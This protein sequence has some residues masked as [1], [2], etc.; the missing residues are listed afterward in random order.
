[1]LPDGV[2]L[3]R[4]IGFGGMASVYEAR[5]RTGE[6]IAVKVMH[7]EMLAAPN[8][9][10]RFLREGKVTASL[11]HEGIPVVHAVHE[12][13]DGTVAIAMELLRGETV[14]DRMER[15][16]GYLGPQEVLAIADRVL[17]VLEVAHA[18][19]VLHRD[20]KPENVFLTVGG[21]LKVLDFG[22][23]RA[24]EAS[25][26]ALTMAG[27][28]LGT[29]A[30]MSPEQAN[31]RWHE[32][33]ARTDLWAVGATMFTALAGEPPHARPEAAEEL[34]A[35]S[36][37]DARPVGSVVGGLKKPV[38]EVVDKVLAKKREDRYGSATEMRA[39]VRGAW[40]S[41][42]GSTSMQVVWDRIASDIIVA[43]PAL[44]EPAA[45][46]PEGPADGAPPAQAPALAAQADPRR[47]P[48]RDPD[49]LGLFHQFPPRVAWML[50]ALGAFALAVLAT[51]VASFMS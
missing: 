9:R 15:R 36:T 42:A 38:C 12:L 50:A 33:D 47:R 28:A 4:R 49:D 37:L 27:H 34:L 14:A 22:M 23:A 39:A 19:E 51:L 45:P 13:P 10:E 21:D 7:R 18:K 16:G 17:A 2:R 26:Q 1:M 29:P 3:G 30:F 32:V 48:P 8:V 40:S 5:S 6:R 41:I 43:N 20:I 35:A 46:A 25:G 44:A 11:R 24:R 31:G